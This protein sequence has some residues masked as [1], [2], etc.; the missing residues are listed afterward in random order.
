MGVPKKSKSNLDPD[1][2]S[3]TDRQVLER[4][5]ALLGLSVEQLQQLCQERVNLN[6][7]LGAYGHN[8]AH[9]NYPSPLSLPSQRASPDQ[10]LTNSNPIHPEDM[11][12]EIPLEA[13]PVV[14]TTYLGNSSGNPALESSGPLP[15]GQTDVSNLSDADR[16]LIYIAR[17][18]ALELEGSGAQFQPLSYGWGE[19]RDTEMQLTNDQPLVFDM[20]DLGLPHH[21]EAPD[22]FNSRQFPDSNNDE[23]GHFPIEG[24]HWADSFGPPES[25]EAFPR[26]G[27]S[28]SNSTSDWSLIEPVRKMEVQYLIFTSDSFNF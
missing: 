21:H 28:A 27:T 9:L 23:S 3:S 8:E 16:Q 15:L 1:S 4:A 7:P 13:N 18:N 14:N 6:L 26:L 20:S 2:L 22:V 12:R 25:L 19:S 11:R 5:A 10:F 17:R 24:N